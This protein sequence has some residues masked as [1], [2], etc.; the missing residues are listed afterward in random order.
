LTAENPLFTVAM[1]TRDAEAHVAEALDSVLAQSCDD[2]EFVVVDGGSTDSTVS[3]LTERE[4][5]FAG[6]LRWV[7]EP[8]DGLYDAMNKAVRMARGRFIVF[9]GADDRLMPDALGTVASE[10]ERHPDVAIWAG[11][12]S[13]VSERGRFA[14]APRRVVRRGM[15]QRAPARHQ[16]LVCR[17]DAITAAGGFDTRYRVAADY[18]LYLKMAEAGAT[19]RLVSATL[20]EFRLGGVSTRNALTTAREYRDVRIAHGA[21]R[22][23]EQVVMYKSVA[24]SWVFSAWMRV[25]YALGTGSA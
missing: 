6:R 5:A 24:A 10:I 14:E 13:V 18:D 20:S 16:S 2:Y 1:V 25:R 15:I 7:S 4:P 8:D 19:E 23:V 22:V 21:G 9:L 12:V 3:T 11:G 17:R